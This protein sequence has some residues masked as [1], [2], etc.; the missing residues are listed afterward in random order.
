MDGVAFTLIIYWI[1]FLILII[2]YILFLFSKIKVLTSN[3]KEFISLI[4]EYEESD[5]NIPVSS[6]GLFILSYTPVPSSE[7]ECI[8]KT[9]PL[10]FKYNG[11][12][13]EVFI[14]QSSTHFS[15][16]LKEVLIQ[17]NPMEI[18]VKSMYEVLDDLTFSKDNYTS[19]YS[20]EFCKKTLN[21]LKQNEDDLPHYRTIFEKTYNTFSDY[22]IF[23]LKSLFII[24]VLGIMFIQGYGLGYYSQHLCEEKKNN[25]NPL[26]REN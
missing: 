17:R 21:W 24:F 10:Y 18:I 23:W 14:D 8:N 13:D 9:Y 11:I 20:I 25:F 2:L 26:P 1:V 3:Y 19:K 6:S 22:Y 16:M 5:N 15:S 7:E 4:N 12:I